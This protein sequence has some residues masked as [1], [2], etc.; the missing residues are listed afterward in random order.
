MK[1]DILRLDVTEYT[2]GRLYF[3][4]LKNS[5]LKKSVENYLIFRKINDLFDELIENK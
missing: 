1:G 3:V 2:Q 4:E 5:I